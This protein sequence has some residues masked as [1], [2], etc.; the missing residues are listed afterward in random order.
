MTDGHGDEA[1]AAAVL[2]SLGIAHTLHHHPPVRTEEDLELTG[3][4]VA[5]SV[6][7]LAFIRRDDARVVLA[8]VPGPARVAYGPLARALG[9]SRAQL[10]AAPV[11]A[12]L[13]LGMQPGGVSPITTAPGVHVVLDEAILS[14][15]V[16]HCGSGP[17]AVTIALAPEDL[18]QACPGAVVASISRWPE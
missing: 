15:P 14:L 13:S 17:P 8:G 18:L 5:H 16:V 7:T 4:P 1:A 11:A 6:K 9:L 2:A 10:A 12:V 3:L